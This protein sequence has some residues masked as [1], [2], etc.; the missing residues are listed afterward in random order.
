MPL[1]W[2]NQRELKGLT[3]SLFRASAEP[4]AEMDEIFSGL[5]HNWL[6]IC[7]SQV[8]DTDDALDLQLTAG[9]VEFDRVCF[10]YVPGCVANSVLFYIHLSVQT[11]RRR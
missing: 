5:K 6:S 9:Q 2:G 1:F 3:R 7:S 8:Q 10:S 11:E 4:G